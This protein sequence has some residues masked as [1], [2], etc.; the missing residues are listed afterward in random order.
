MK[1]KIGSIIETSLVD[2]I[3]APSFVIWFSGC[4]FR[5]PWCHA[6]PL[7]FGAGE[8][9]E[10][11]ELIE[12]I[13][14]SAYAV[15]YVQVTGGEPTLQPEGLEKLFEKVKALGLKTSL[16]TNS[17]NPKVIKKLV[18][19]KLI[20]HYATDLKT[21][22]IA[23]KYS[24][25][26]GVKDKETVE[27]I[28]KSLSLV[29][30]VPL[31]EIRTTFVPKLIAENDIINGLKKIKRILK[32]KTFIFV[33]QQFYPFENLIDK[34]YSKREV[35][36]HEELIEIAKKIKKASNIKKVFVRSKKGI[37]EV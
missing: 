6:A 32:N 12:K 1:V 5:C 11:N 30:S 18:N 17:S 3:G 35:I 14:E 4:N 33:L 29:K 2:V 24:K 23:E 28:K 7:V 26:I 16:D 10:I 15:E 20:D 21:D 8:W 27:K 36:A 9:I 22:L 25:V 37:E 13:K 19:K 31:V 34:E